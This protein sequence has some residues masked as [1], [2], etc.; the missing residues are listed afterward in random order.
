MNTV[1][2]CNSPQCTCDIDEDQCM[3]LQIIS[4]EDGINRYLV[5]CNAKCLMEWLDQ[6]EICI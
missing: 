4:V 1:I 5:F 2:F 6:D 3:R